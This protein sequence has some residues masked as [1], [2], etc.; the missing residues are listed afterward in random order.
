MDKLK[1]LF[2]LINTS[3]KKNTVYL[4]LLIF[5]TTLFDV[6]GVASIMPF[7]AIL[8]D[9]KLIET[10]EVFVEMFRI[11][12][13]F[14]VTNVN[15][16]VFFL[17]TLFFI[18]LV[19]SLILRMVTV[20]A[21]THFVLKNEHEISMRLVSKYLSHEYGWFLGK[22]SANLGKIILTD[23]GAVIGFGILPLIKI[24]TQIPIVV[25]LL[26]LL[27]TVNKSV[28][29][30]A[31]ILLVILYG[32]IWIGTRKSVE[33]MGASYIESNQ[34]RYKLI[35]EIFGAI[36]EI[37]AGGWEKEFTKRFAIPS[38]KY[39]RAYAN[40]TVTEQIPRYGVE[41]FVFGG[42]LLVILSVISSGGSFFEAVPVIA[43][44]A[45]AGYRLIPAMQQIYAALTQLRFVGPA[46]DVVYGGLI[47]S[48]NNF[49]SDRDRLD[50]EFK[51]SIVLNGV[52]FEYP[53]GSREAL[54]NIKLEIPVGTKTAIFGASGSG[55]STL[56]DIIM[57]LLKPQGGQVLIDDQAIDDSNSRSWQK[58][59]GYVSQNIVLIDDSIAANIAFGE[60]EDSVNIEGV[61]RVAKLA[62]I[63][64]YI[65]GSLPEKYSTRVGERG[66]RLSGGQ[67]QRIGIARALYRNPKVLILDEATSALDSQN[68]EL[69]IDAINKLQTKLTVI[70][71]SH[72][73]RTIKK[74]D[75]IYQLNNGSLKYIGGVNEFAAY[76][77]GIEKYD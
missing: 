69:I 52:D 13:R 62:N 42:V 55:K 58:S 54:R 44:F 74:C 1:K 65:D 47:G 5:V 34:Q 75:R 38:E 12:Q 2:Y 57:C 56:I 8:I 36:K 61:V 68:E 22:H 50:F 53:G 19:M 20:Y 39:A 72:R 18:L 23:V 70:I 10:N 7:L 51:K 11:T 45:L 35:S 41:G 4:L 33:L 30:F 26:L 21:Q 76:K 31:G 46:I 67:R 17:G 24:I 73:M 63:H 64:D 40:A 49:Q 14:G 66:V 9:P 37:K 6:V 71:I 60:E 29:I 77:Q 43:L 59:V 3:N 32:G 16:F 25:A 27:V 15:E 48:E 28:A